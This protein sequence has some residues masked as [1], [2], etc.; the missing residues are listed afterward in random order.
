MGS[1]EM[2]G[3]F[4]LDHS[5]IDATVSRTSPGNYALGYVDEG[6]FVVFY[7]GRSDADVAQR[8]HEWVGAPAAARRHASLARAAWGVRRRAGFPIDVPAFGRVATEQESGYTSFAYSY[9]AS[10]DSAFGEEC[11]NF[12][13]F[14][15]AGGLDNA[16]APTP[17]ASGHAA[18]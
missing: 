7:V 3:P 9:A 17:P 14:G 8:L 11:R 18:S 13:E 5:V 6:T 1:L 16:S 12:E 4:P 2:S 10:A 15:G